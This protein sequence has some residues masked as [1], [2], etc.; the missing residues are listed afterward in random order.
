M[1]ATKRNWVCYDAECSLC[2]RWV[3]RFR[4]LLEKNGFA[5]FPLQSP[6]VRAALQLPETDL[7]KEM[8]VITATGRVVGG[9]DALAY[10]SRIVCK[11]VFWLTRIPGA[12]PL[13]RG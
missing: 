12:M 11:P 8:R 4:A 13:M 10:V 6:E 5:L 3:E 9:A 7:L 2:I 1:N